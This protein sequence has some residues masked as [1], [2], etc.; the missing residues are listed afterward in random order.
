MPC[1]L[2]STLTLHYTL[3]IFTVWKRC[4]TM[5]S[6]IVQSQYHRC[7][8]LKVPK[9]NPLLQLQGLLSSVPVIATIYKSCPDIYTSEQMDEPKK[10]QLKHSIGKEFY[11]RDQKISV[12]YNGKSNWT[13]IHSPCLNIS[14]GKWQPKIITH[15]V[16]C[17]SYSWKIIHVE[18]GHTDI[19]NM[20]W[21]TLI[22]S[23]AGQIKHVRVNIYVR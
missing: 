21:Y 6:C 3:K 20:I 1:T 22:I 5:S 19:Q 4:M 13:T 17:T 8:L 23:V 14:G 9:I 10:S 12:R 18:Q 2:K 16:L 7:L 11:I 15:Q